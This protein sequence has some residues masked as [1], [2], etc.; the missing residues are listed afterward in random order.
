MTFNYDV[1]VVGAGHAGCEAAAAAAN[2]GSKTLLITMD[3]NKIAQMSC[4][5]AVGGIAKG[6]IVR[7][8]DALGGYMGIVTDQTAIQFRMLNRS[9]G[10][11]MWS[12]RAQSDRARFIDCW[13]GILENMLNLSIWQ[14]MVQELIIEHGQVCG[15]RT[16]MNVVFRA[17]AV[18]LTNGTF[19][20]GLLHIGR[21]QIRGGRIAEPAATGLTEQLVSLGIQTDRMKTGTPVRIDGRSVHFDEMEEQPGENDFHKFSY[22]DTSHRKLKQLSCW[23]T[24]TNE[25]CHD[26][27]RE[28]LPDSP[29]YNGQIKSIGP[30]YCPSIETKIVTFADKTQHQLFLEP[31]G[32]ATQEYY[33]NGFSSSL[34]LDI[35]LRALQAIPAFRDVQIYRPGYAIEY[36]FFDPTQ[37]RH[38]LET[39]QIRNLFFAG[40]INGTTGYEEAGGQGLVAGINAHINCHGGQP[41]ILGRDEAYIGVLIDDLVTKGVDEPYRMFTSRAEYRI[42]LRQDDADMRLTEKS[43]QMGLAKQDRYDLLREKKESRDAIIRFAETYSVKPQ[44]IN[45]GLEKLGTAPLSHGCKLFDVVL[46]PQTTLENLADLV[47]ALRAELDKVPASRKEEII[48]AA[49]ILIK[50][51]GYIKREQIIADKINRLENIRIKGKFDYNS[52]QSLSTEARQKLTRID[53]DTIAQASRIPGISPSDINILLVLLGR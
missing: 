3:M 38:N 18:V 20:N 31:E 19:L 4:N 13:R 7:E 47:P 5:P 6:Q 39:K 9:K 29:L 43:Y 28:G 51:S 12:P 53:P 49:E 48:E 46:R 26:I 41:F 33:L 21:T 27:L 15:V 50:Y 40:Q 10:P 30:R 16:G 22:M 25:A 35:Q 2:L 52:I 42:L 36:D 11:A 37:L 45:S 1:I 8:I 34:P 14:D 23:T 44:Y 32:E 24:F 17:G